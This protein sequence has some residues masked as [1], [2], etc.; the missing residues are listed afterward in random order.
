MA[1]DSPGLVQQITPTLLSFCKTSNS[2]TS[3][4]LSLTAVRFKLL[5]LS[6]WL[7]LVQYCTRFYMTSAWCLAN[8]VI[9]Y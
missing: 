2:V 1:S 6:V 3:T 9:Q 8:F 5:I 4:V 7:R